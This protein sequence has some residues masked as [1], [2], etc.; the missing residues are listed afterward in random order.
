MHQSYDEESHICV[1]RSNGLGSDFTAY[2]PLQ[3]DLI[4]SRTCISSTLFFVWLSTNFLEHFTSQRSVKDHRRCGSQKDC[5][6]HRDSSSPSSVTW[7]RC[8][9]ASCETLLSSAT[10]WI[11]LPPC[12]R[13]WIV[14]TAAVEG[15]AEAD[16]LLHRTSVPIGVKSGV[17]T[18]TS[19]E[20]FDVESKPGVLQRQQHTSY[21]SYVWNYFAKISW[22]NNGSE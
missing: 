15:S 3:H 18:F 13:F 4:S 14:V 17:W 19:P 8:V 21:P 2:P 5:A 20:K 10:L 12:A 9:S 11:R 22:H 1:W 6:N 7:L 16:C